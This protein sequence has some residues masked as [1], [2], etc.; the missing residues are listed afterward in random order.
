MKR[1]TKN[2][3]IG[4][5][6]VLA[7]IAIGVFVFMNKANEG[8][9]ALSTIKIENVDLSTIDDGA[10][11]GDYKVFPI[12]VEVKVI[13]ANHTISDIII[14]KHTNGQ[15]KPAEAIIDQVITSQS[16]QVDTVSGATYSSKVILKAIENA[17]NRD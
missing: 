11:Q 9:E 16:L 17:L 13:V 5:L 8:L 14:E 4:I 3:I 10:Y 6:L 1:R 15:G 7:L 12:T 2:I